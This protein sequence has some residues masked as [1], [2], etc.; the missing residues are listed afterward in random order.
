MPTNPKSKIKN[1]KLRS[2]QPGASKGDDRSAA[3]RIAP[4]CLNKLSVFHNGGHS[5][6][7]ARE[8]KH[9]ALPLAVVHS[10]IFGELDV[11]RVV[12]I[13]CLLAIGTVGLRV[14]YY[15]HCYD[16]SLRLYK[17]LIEVANN[18]KSKS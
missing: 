12:M 4:T 5:W 1:R 6:I 3:G 11:I 10:V 9:L 17:Y 18:F 7:A 14:H 15:G 2:R 16:L 13:A 8:F